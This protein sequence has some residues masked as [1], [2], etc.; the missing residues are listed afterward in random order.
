M[1]TRAKS[2]V[3]F[4]I[5]VA[6][7]PALAAPSCDTPQAVKNVEESH[8]PVAVAGPAYGPIAVGARVSIN[9]VSSPQIVRGDAFTLEGGGLLH[10]LKPGTAT[11]RFQT[12]AGTEDL[13]YNALAVDSVDLQQCPGAGTP[14][15]VTPSWDVLLPFALYAGGKAGT[16]LVAGDLCPFVAPPSVPLKCGQD[17][18]DFTL[19]S[20][21]TGTITSTAD[22]AVRLDVEGVPLDAI[23]GLEISFTALPGGASADML[24]VATRQGRQMNVDRFQ[25]QVRVETPLLCGID[26]A[27]TDGISHGTVVG[28]GVSTSGAQAPLWIYKKQAGACEVSAQLVG[29][30]VTASGQFTF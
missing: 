19:Q 17:Y 25:R 13:D 27:Q 12:V 24:V 6:L 1:D 11:V 4:A 18:L 29:T 22:P 7:F 23:D 28:T 26:G 20:G 15:L 10:A 30:S 3:T 14:C 16:K 21:A 8:L 5:F 2:T 9:T